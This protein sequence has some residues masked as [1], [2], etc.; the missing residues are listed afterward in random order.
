LQLNN[1]GASLV[2]DLEPRSYA[3]I[4]GKADRVFAL[5]P[6]L[7]YVALYSHGRPESRQRGEPAGVSSAES[8]RYE[9]LLVNP[10]VIKLVQ[11]RGNSGHSLWELLPQLV[12]ALKN[13]HISVCFELSAKPLEFAGRVEAIALSA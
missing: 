5:S 6:A 7:R 8:D 11:A 4:F 13:G 2:R 3:G 1:F 9:E 10:T 12:I